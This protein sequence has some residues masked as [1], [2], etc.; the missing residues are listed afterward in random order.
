MNIRCESVVKTNAEGY[1]YAQA[2]WLATPKLSL[3]VAGVG[4]NLKH[5]EYFFDVVVCEYV[6]HMI[7]R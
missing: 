5:L 1:S 7:P 2:R 4:T 6:A 3:V